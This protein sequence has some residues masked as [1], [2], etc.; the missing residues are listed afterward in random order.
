MLARYK[1]TFRSGYC[2]YRQV[3]VVAEHLSQAHEKACAE[4]TW[5]AELRGQNL[6]P[7]SFQL[8]LV[9]CV[10]APFKPYLMRDCKI[11][12]CTGKPGY[13]WVQGWA[14]VSAPGRVSTPMRLCDAQEVLRK[15]KE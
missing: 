8:E 1:Y 7:R 6:S 3:T 11:E 10:P 15:L 5:R 12:A 13:R 9:R 4:L 14:V 2:G